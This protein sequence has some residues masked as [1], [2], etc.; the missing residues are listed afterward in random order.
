VRTGSVSQQPSS[1][2][3][4]GRPVPRAPIHSE[5]G[6]R[7]ATFPGWNS[8][9][10]TSPLSAALNPTL[11]WEGILQSVVLMARILAR[12]GPIDTGIELT[13]DRK[14]F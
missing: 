3:V 10:G 1:S 12:T 6:A 13:L 2:V 11:R 14:I 8:R 9:R 5:R 4:T 7:S